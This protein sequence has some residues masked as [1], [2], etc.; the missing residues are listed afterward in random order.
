MAR[1]SLASPT[2]GE[3]AVISSLFLVK[4]SLTE[5]DFS[6]VMISARRSVWRNSSRPSAMRS[7]ASPG[8]IFS[9]ASNFG[10]LPRF[11]H[12]RPAL[13]RDYIMHG[14][15]WVFAGHRWWWFALETT[16]SPGR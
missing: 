3:L 13:C 12:D 4:V 2:S 9:A 14:G 15:K 11:A 8:L 7:L 5:L 1:L 16:A 6:L 10:R